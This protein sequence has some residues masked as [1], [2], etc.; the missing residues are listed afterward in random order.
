[1]KSFYRKQL[2]LI[3]RT[4]ISFLR[5]R[6]TITLRQMF[7]LFL[8]RW[9]YQEDTLLFFLNLMKVNKNIMSLIDSHMISLLD[10]IFPSLSKIL[11]SMIHQIAQDIIQTIIQLLILS[12]SFRSLM[13]MEIKSL[14]LQ[15]FYKILLLLKLKSLQRVGN[16]EHLDLYLQISN[17]LLSYFLKIYHKPTLVGML[18]TDF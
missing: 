6:S 14:G 16:G 3:S 17:M 12:H 2:R 8:K 7:P 11:V 5:P 1:M 15:K 18:T 9:Q 10:K 13:N 4:L